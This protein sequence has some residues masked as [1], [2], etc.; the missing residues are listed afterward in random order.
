MHPFSTPWK[1]Y[2]FLMFSGGKERVN[3]E[4]MDYYFAKVLI[5]LFVAC[6][7]IVENSQVYSFLLA[8]D[9]VHAETTVGMFE[10]TL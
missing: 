10:I 7:D 6:W 2:G 3:W 9:Y 1:P 8:F 4:R 5:K